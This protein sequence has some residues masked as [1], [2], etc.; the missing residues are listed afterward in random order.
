MIELNV[1]QLS[2]E[3]FEARCG[4]PTASNF[5]KIVT[6]KGEWSTQSK[7]YIYQLA[8]EAIIGIK[9]ETFTTPAMQ[10]GIDLESE[11]R[12]LYELIYDVEVKTTGLCY[13][14]ELK[15]YS[16]SPDGLVGEDGII[17]IKCP[18]IHTHIEYLL[19]GKLPTAYI[20]QVQGGLYITSREWCDFMSYY[21]GLKPMI[22]RVERDENFISRL[23]HAL[24]RFTT[25][26][27]ETIEKLKSL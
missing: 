20:Q 13:A 23:A 25:E 19:S 14:N 4:I 2:D 27:A 5:S 17:E 15:R 7:Q 3:W 11:A 9:T 10:R 22:V 21:P 1:P 12:G 18:L 26:L 24:D 8:G 16:C 6:S